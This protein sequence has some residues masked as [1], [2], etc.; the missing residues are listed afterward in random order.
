LK[1]QE[2]TL[3]QAH[4]DFN[5]Q[6][7]ELHTLQTRYAELQS[8]YKFTVNQHQDQMNESHRQQ[9]HHIQTITLELQSLQSKHHDNQVCMSSH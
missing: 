1:V 2:Q 5:H 8:Q 3:R 9:K 4:D 6:R 7:N